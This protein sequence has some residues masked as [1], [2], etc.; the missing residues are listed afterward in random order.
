MTEMEYEGPP[1]VHVPRVRNWM[2]P[3]LRDW[4]RALYPPHRGTTIVFGCLFIVPWAIYQAV[5]FWV[6]LIG[7]MFVLAV[8]TLMAISDLITYHDR[9]KKAVVAAWG[10][11]MTEL[12]DKPPP[13]AIA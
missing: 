13:P 10:P 8:G 11:Y 1:E 6:W 2:G 9:H 4:N 12:H 3:A 7:V 5:K